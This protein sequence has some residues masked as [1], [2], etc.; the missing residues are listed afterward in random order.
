MGEV[1]RDEHGL[2]ISVYVKGIRF[3]KRVRGD[4][5]EAKN[6][7][8]QIENEART[9][10][11]DPAFWFPKSKV[12]RRYL[13]ENPSLDLTFATAVELWRNQT[14]SEL[15]KASKVKYESLLRKHILPALGGL[16]L[17]DLNEKTLRSFRS[18]LQVNTNI[19]RNSILTTVETILSANGIKIWIKR[20]KETKPLIE[21]FDREEIERIIKAIHDPY[22][23]Y[24]TVAFE[25]GMRPSEEIALKWSQVDFVHEAIHV[26]EACVLNVG[27][28]TKTQR[29]IRDI[30]ISPRCMIALK[31]QKERTFLNSGHVFLN[32]HGQPCHQHHL[33]RDVWK[34]ALRRAGV[35][36]RNMRNTRHTFAS[37][38]LS[39]GENYMWVAEQMG[40]N[41]ITVFSR[42]AKFV[43]SFRRRN[44]AEVTDAK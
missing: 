44:G 17:S 8:H 30:E 19:T 4:E 28:M 12:T 7:A 15:S 35:R 27:G 37:L 6:I 33:L 31:R 24:F 40:D 41:P 26:D 25:T 20:L 18:E 14:K 23:E 36:Y 38:K 11:F 32:L 3:R 34:P 22:K 2:I 9:G 43:K 13:N 42:Y 29:S 10:R 5:D 1:K 16:R 39:E 21:P